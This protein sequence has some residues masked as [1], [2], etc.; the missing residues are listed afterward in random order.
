MHPP[1]LSCRIFPSKQQG[2]AKFR[3]LS[4]TY[5]ERIKKFFI[6]EDCMDRN[7]IRKHAHNTFGR[8]YRKKKFIPFR[9][10]FF[11]FLQVY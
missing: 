11:L 1:N 8:R 4:Q 10:E 2:K 9:K 6:S 7:Y 3:D 5:V